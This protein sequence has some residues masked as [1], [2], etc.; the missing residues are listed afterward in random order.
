MLGFTEGFIGLAKDLQKLGNTHP[1]HEPD[2][3][4]GGIPAESAVA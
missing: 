2:E 4:L 1:R 3:G